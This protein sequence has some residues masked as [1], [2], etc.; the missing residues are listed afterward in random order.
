MA[1]ADRRLLRQQARLQQRLPHLLGE[2]AVVAG[3]ASREMGELRVI[4]APLA[5]PVEPLE[6]PAGG[7]LRRIGVL[8]RA[9]RSRRPEP[10]TASTASSK[11]SCAPAGGRRGARRPR[12]SAAGGAR[13][14][15]RAAR[16]RRS[17]PGGSAS[18]R[19]RRRSIPLGVLVEGEVDELGVELR[20]GVGE[21]EEAAGELAGAQA[22]GR[23]GRRAAPGSA[24]STRVPTTAAT[25][26]HSRSETA[27]GSARSAAA[28]GSAARR[29]RRRAIADLHGLV[30]ARARLGELGAAVREASLRTSR[31]RAAAEGGASAPPQASSSP[32]R[33]VICLPY[34]HGR[35]SPRRR[36]RAACRASSS[37]TRPAARPSGAAWR[38][39]AQPRRRDR[40]GGLRGRCRTRSRRWSRS[41]A[42]DRATPRCRRSMCTRKSPRT[43]RVSTPVVEPSEG[44]AR[45]PGRPPVQRRRRPD[46]AG[47]LRDAARARADRACRTRRSAQPPRDTRRRPS[48]TDLRVV[49]RHRGHGDARAGTRRPTTRARSITTSVTPGSGIPA[50]ART[51]TIT[52]LV[53]N[54]TQTYRVYAVDATG[55]E[56]ALS[57]PLTGDDRAAT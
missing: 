14:S 40:R 23:R 29:S 2:R 47:L 55:N 6:D 26:S 51:K 37:A 19:A 33:A 5:H 46:E 27:S 11:S 24:S 28:A 57:A 9:R 12:R 34:R 43:W 7:A 8:V 50:T 3:E 1:L 48:P 31:R 15:A 13:R 44:R 38:V 4:S 56:S 39:G 17:R 45:I 25:S 41:C 22:G 49:S 30:L 21:H 52:G 53:P 35:T 54:Y 16:R 10:S 32:S 42:A 20:G 36:P 18:A